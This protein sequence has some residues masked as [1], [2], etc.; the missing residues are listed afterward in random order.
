MLMA[1]HSSRLFVGKNS[2]CSNNAFIHSL[3]N[4]QSHDIR[5]AR[6][7]YKR[8]QAIL[9]VMAKLSYVSNLVPYKSLTFLQGLPSANVVKCTVVK[10]TASSHSIPRVWRMRFPQSTFPLREAKMP[11]VYIPWSEPMSA[12]RSKPFSLADDWVQ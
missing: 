12:V 5:V 3:K 2:V 4:S 7:F 9:E 6:L 1:P 11:I 10:C 8:C